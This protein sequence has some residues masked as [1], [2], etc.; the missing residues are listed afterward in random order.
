MTTIKI[1][2]LSNAYN[3]KLLKVSNSKKNYVIKLFLKKNNSNFVREIFFLS[4]LKNHNNIPKIISYD[5]Q[6]KILV[7]AITEE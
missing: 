5:Y 2:N 4:N 6:S 3:S 7:L 1:S